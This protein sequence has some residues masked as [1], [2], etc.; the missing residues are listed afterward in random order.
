[1]LAAQANF[2]IKRDTGTKPLARVIQIERFDLYR[3]AR[4]G[5]F[6]DH[7]TRGG[8]ASTAPPLASVK[9]FVSPPRWR[10]DRLGSPIG[11][12]ANNRS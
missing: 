2:G 11:L 8:V 6:L 1:M 9:A 4:C 5:E 12:D 10:G 7:H 3:A